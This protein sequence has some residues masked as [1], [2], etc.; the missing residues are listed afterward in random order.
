MSKKSKIAEMQQLRAAGLTL[1]HADRLSQNKRG[2][3]VAIAAASGLAILLV[4]GIV[5]LSFELTRT[6][7]PVRTAALA[8]PTVEPAPAPEV[9][10][11]TAATVNPDDLAAQTLTALTHARHSQ[12]MLALERE[13]EVTMAAGGASAQIG[14]EPSAAKAETSANALARIIETADTAQVDE[15]APEMKANCT[16]TLGKELRSISIPFGLSSTTMA[17][18][19]TEIL[20]GIVADLNNC[21]EARLMI[22]GHS[23]GTGEELTNMQLSWKRAEATMAL[24][25]ALGAKPSQ[26][27]AVGFGAR[28]PM[29]PEASPADAANRRV[30]FRVLRNEGVNG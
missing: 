10:A 28:V 18:A 15:A 29:S 14:V 16:A 12:S 17:A 13:D 2:P 6:S 20:N 23:D 4:V 25:V 3:G 22:N 9:P 19:E 5:A 30:D 21:E 11:P 26:L 27:E 8:Q 1:A 7:E 24:M